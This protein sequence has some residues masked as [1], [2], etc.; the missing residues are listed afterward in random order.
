MARDASNAVNRQGTVVKNSIRQTLNEA[1]ANVNDAVVVDG[2]ALAYRPNIVQEIS[3]RTW[4]QLFQE[5]K[6]SENQFFAALSVTSSD[7]ALA[8]GADQL[9]DLMM[10]V[11]TK[12][13][14]IRITG[15]NGIDDG[16]II[17]FEGGNAPSA[18]EAKQI[19]IVTQDR[20]VP[21]RSSPARRIK[22]SRK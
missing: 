15:A 18:N 19:P 8:V 9:P 16:T 17:P 12:T 10:T 5:R 22:L 6:I 11:L 13:S 20:A 2:V 1:G 4:Y 21:V 14:D 3:P 7:A